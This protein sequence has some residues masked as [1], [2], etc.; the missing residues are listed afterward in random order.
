MVRTN[1]SKIK[2]L[3]PRTERRIMTN[4]RVTGKEAYELRGQDQLYRGIYRTYD[5]K[6]F[7]FNTYFM[8]K[9]TANKEARLL[10]EKGNHVRVSEEKG[11]NGKHYVL[12]VRS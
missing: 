9:A 6:R 4:P 2:S 10:R 5:G 12:W 8:N 1:K 11:S 3:M 7:Y